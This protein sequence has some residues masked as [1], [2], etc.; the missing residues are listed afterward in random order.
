MPDSQTI[1]PTSQFDVAASGKSNLP[2]LSLSASD[3]SNPLTWAPKVRPPQEDSTPQAANNPRA[4]AAAGTEAAAATIAAIVGHLV[5]D[6][7]A[8]FNNSVDPFRIPALP[9][10]P[11]PVPEG[12]AWT[13]TKCGNDWME[14][15][16]R[17]S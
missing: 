13:C 16:R 5:C 9:P 2:V 10:L 17:C 6:L 14:N 4:N 11:A 1:Q 7:S 3:P 8:S 12:P 15:R